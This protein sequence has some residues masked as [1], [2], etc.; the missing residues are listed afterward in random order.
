MATWMT[1][2]LEEDAH[3][4]ADRVVPSTPS[5]EGRDLNDRRRVAYLAAVLPELRL[6]VRRRLML[7]AESA[8]ALEIAQLGEALGRLES[9]FEVAW[10]ARPHIHDAIHDQTRESL[11]ALADLM[12]EIDTVRARRD[13]AHL[14]LGLSEAPDPVDATPGYPIYPYR[15]YE[16]AMV[17]TVIRSLSYPTD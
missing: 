14:A 17:L 4:L 13:G 11:R 9:D 5:R 3:R 7:L 15:G 16:A 8:P 6:C 1:V 2:S 12:T 10:K